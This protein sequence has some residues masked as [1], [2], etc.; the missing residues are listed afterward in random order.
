MFFASCNCLNA[1][2]TVC[3]SEMIAPKAGMTIMMARIWRIVRF[4]I[5]NGLDTRKSSIWS[6]RRFGEAT[7][8]LTWNRPSKISN[9]MKIGD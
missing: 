4:C 6:I 8:N 1:A 2:G 5:G 3:D 9:V 7:V